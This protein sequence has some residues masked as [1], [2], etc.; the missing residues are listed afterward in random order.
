M[1]YKTYIKVHNMEN[2]RKNNKYNQS[3]S[4]AQFRTMKQ[5]VKQHK[6]LILLNQL[7]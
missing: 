5:T 2:E 3:K 6:A 1:F 7:D 4:K